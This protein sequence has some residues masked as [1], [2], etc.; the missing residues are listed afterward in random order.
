MHDTFSQQAQYNTTS[1]MEVIRCFKKVF[2]KTKPTQLRKDGGTEFR[3]K[4]VRDS[5]SDADYQYKAHIDYTIS[6]ISE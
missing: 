2:D 5:S 4:R 3:A 1:A 6:S